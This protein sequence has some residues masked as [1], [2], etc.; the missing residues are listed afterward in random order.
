[1]MNNRTLPPDSSRYSI[2]E[3][4]SICDVSDLQYATCRS[5]QIASDLD[6]LAKA[7]SITNR[8][9]EVNPT[10]QAVACCEYIAR[11]AAIAGEEQ[12]EEYRQEAV[13]RSAVVTQTCGNLKLS[14][15][16][17]H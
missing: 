8:S 9:F 11:L 7:S 10:Q 6:S 4:P 2:I 5:L 1:M 14:Q 13:L 17:V 3:G 15:C 16:N 12:E